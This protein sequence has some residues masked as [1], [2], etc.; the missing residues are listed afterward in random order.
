MV[1]TET[2]PTVWDADRDEPFFRLVA[3]L[4][5]ASFT[6]GASVLLASNGDEAPTRANT[7]VTC[8]PHLGPAR[9][10]A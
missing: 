9:S 10:R 3:L 5:S 8:P 4:F 2:L 6:A 1:R 7:P